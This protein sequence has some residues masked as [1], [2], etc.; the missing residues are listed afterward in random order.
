MTQELSIA[1][2]LSSPHLLKSSI[3][4]LD[5]LSLLN[6]PEPRLPILMLKENTTTSL[7]LNDE[8]SFFKQRYYFFAC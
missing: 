4:V 6:V 5:Q 8:T 1:L 2:L 3:K 7:P